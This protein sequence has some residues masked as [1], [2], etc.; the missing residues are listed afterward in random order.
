MA[1]TFIRIRICECIWPS[2][3]W[4]SVWDGLQ[5]ARFKIVN[6]V[7]YCPLKICRCPIWLP[8]FLYTWSCVFYIC[9]FFLKVQ[10]G[11]R[12]PSDCFDAH[13]AELLKTLRKILGKDTNA[14]NVQPT[15]C[16]GISV[17]FSLIYS[18]YFSWLGA[19]FFPFSWKSFKALRI[20]F[21]IQS[22]WWKVRVSSSP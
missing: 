12:W 19:V 22:P 2:S 17:I 10:G 16:A 9:I 21:E 1:A 6:H 18:D 11:G 5:V 20:S 4:V 7:V 8:L 14:R 3:I 15:R 13:S